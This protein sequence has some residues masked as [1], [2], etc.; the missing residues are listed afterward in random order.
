[1]RNDRMRKWL[2]VEDTAGNGPTDPATG[3][4]RRRANP[5]YCPELVWLGRALGV[6]GVCVVLGSGLLACGFPA[7]SPGISTLVVVASMCWNG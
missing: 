2:G 1:M 3:S 4:R 5:H 7:W 6:L